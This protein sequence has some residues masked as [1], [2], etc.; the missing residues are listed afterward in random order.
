LHAG[1]LMAII[2][3]YRRHLAELLSAMVRGERAGWT[4]AAL[5]LVGTL[6]A[7]IMGLGF[8]SWFEGLADDPGSVSVCL[9]ITGAVLLALLLVRRSAK[10]LGLLSALWIGLA[11][12]LAIAPGISRSCTTIV[13]ARHLGI[14][15]AKAAEFSFMLSIPA[16][17]GANLVELKKY[18]FA[19]GGIS[20][21][22]LL[23]GV[24]VA[25]LVGYLALNL[26][27]RLLNANRLWL[28][29]F[30]CLL[31]GATGLIFLR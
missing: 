28:F 6:P 5:I 16:I 26:L 30:Y 25:A 9:L 29:G 2:F 18:G 15:P 1:T 31:I 23:L 7:A 3:Y 21:L 12:A 14:E 13:L 19:L 10:P 8:Q 11:Q 20:P 22:T 17:A 4:Y 27:V 24:I